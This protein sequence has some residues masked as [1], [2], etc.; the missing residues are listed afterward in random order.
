MQEHAR[1]RRRNGSAKAFGKDYDRPKTQLLCGV[2]H[3]EAT[4]LKDASEA[5]G[6]AVGE[7]LGPNRIAAIA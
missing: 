1:T 2:T 4:G 7:E 3:S 6:G 5:W